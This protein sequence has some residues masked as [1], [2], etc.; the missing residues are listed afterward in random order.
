MLKKE[1][2]LSPRELN[3]LQQRKCLSRTTLKANVSRAAD[4]ER[5]PEFQRRKTQE[6]SDSSWNAIT[7]KNLKI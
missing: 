7:A 4:T 6:L 3:H 1:K 2:V 5:L